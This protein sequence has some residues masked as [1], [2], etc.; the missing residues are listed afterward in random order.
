MIDSTLHLQQV[1]KIPSAKTK[2]K[3]ATVP[4]KKPVRQQPEGLKMRFK[5]IGFGSGGTGKIGGES[6]SDSDSES[7]DD[8]STAASRRA[9]RVP[10][11]APGL[12]SDDEMADVQNAS[13]IMSGSS[14]G[15]EDTT[16]RSKAKNS[17]AKVNK[18]TSSPLKRKLDAREDNK[19]SG[20]VPS[21]SPKIK[22]SKPKKIKTKDTPSTEIPQVSKSIETGPPATSLMPP[23]PSATK[24]GETPVPA[25]IRQNSTISRSQAS[26]R[27][28]ETPILPPVRRSSIISQTKPSP[29]PSARQESTILPPRLSRTPSD[30]AMKSKPAVDPSTDAPASPTASQTKSKAE[31]KLEKAARK[32]EKL[33]KKQEK[34]AKVKLEESHEGASEPTP[35]KKTKEAKESKH[36]AEQAVNGST[37]A[38][39]KKETAILPPTR[40][41]LHT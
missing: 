32:E 5:P 27:R 35:R 37:M 13:A 12:D 18:N 25:P 10:P 14:D 31:R 1:V 26:P 41:G 9:F 11:V 40:T 7:E 2:S 3:T 20:S 21:K 15:D 22:E 23:P 39:P 6:S 30:M 8:A 38:T 16:S 17:I 24:K 19:T 33:K 34:A 28:S 4:Q 36:T 29:S